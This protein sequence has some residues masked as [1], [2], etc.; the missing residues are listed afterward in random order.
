MITEA[1]GLVVGA[2][3][4]IDMAKQ[5]WTL[6][7]SYGKI[8]LQQLAVSL[9]SQVMDLAQQNVDL[10]SHVLSLKEEADKL[11]AAQTTA[12]E[13]VVRD[14]RYYRKLP[15]GKEDGPFCLRCWDGDGMLIRKYVYSDQTTHCPQCDIIRS[16]GRRAKT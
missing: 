7:Q 10:Q 6:S 12:A 8:E 5:V 1:A 9:M 13:L 16:A 4:A 3:A 11:K 14:N 2:R 15:D